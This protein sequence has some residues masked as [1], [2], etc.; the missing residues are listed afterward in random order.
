MTLLFCDSFDHYATAQLATKWTSI[1]GAPSIS[2]TFARHGAGGLSCASNQFVRLTFSAFPSIGSNSFNSLIVGF[3][4]KQSSLSVSQ[5]FR[6]GGANNNYFGMTH[7]IGGSTVFTNNTTRDTFLISDHDTGW[8]FYEVKA[9]IH[10]TN[11]T[12]HVIVRL[13]GTEVINLQNTVFT[14]TT[15]S[16]FLFVDLFCNGTACHYDDFYILDPSTPPNNDFIGE[17][18]IQTMMPDGTASTNTD[19]TPSAGSNYQ[20][21]DEIPPNSDTDYNFSSTVG[22]K[23]THTTAGLTAPASVK[24]IYGVQVNTWSRKTDSSDRNVA[25]VA[26]SGSTTVSGNSIPVTTTYRYYSDNWE[27]DPDT[28]AAWT[29]SGVNNAEFGYEVSL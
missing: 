3:A 14:T 23:D 24:D 5:F 21:V 4:Q 22:D 10:P 8:H 26:L 18:R 6:I 9:T 20:N 11:G 2:G 1:S 15:T 29:E 28:S 25:A 12:G 17:V 13:D 16:T 27:E 7:A 19:F